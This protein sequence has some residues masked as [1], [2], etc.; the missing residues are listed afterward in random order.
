MLCLMNHAGFVHLF[1][2]AAGPTFQS[3]AWQA[4]VTVPRR[5][6]SAATELMVAVPEM[7]DSITEGTILEWTKKPGDYVNMDDVVVIIETDKVSLL[8]EL[9]CICS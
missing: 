4:P 8:A 1:Q 7:G 2:V 9:C 3:A 5:W 6:M